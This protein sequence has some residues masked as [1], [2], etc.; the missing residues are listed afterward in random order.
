MN[1]KR[2]IIVL[3]FSIIIFGSS[4]ISGVSFE[5]NLNKKSENS[6]PPEKTVLITGFESWALYTPNP[7]QLIAENLSNIEINGAKVVS[8]IVPVLWGEAVDF[9]TQAIIDFEPDIVISIGTGMID[10]IHVEKIG[11]NL[12][13]CREPDNE[14]KIFLFRR[15]DPHGP[16]LRF[17]NLPISNIVRKINRADIPAERTY[18]AGS[19]IC[20]EVFYGVLN[21]I[22]RKDLSIDAGFIHV[23]LLSNQDPDNGMEL[24]DMIDAIEIAISACL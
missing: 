20:N 24:E 19:F 14:G 9:I 8:I 16:F 11:K 12:K 7:S 21:F 13:S 23:P 4:V 17:S 1:L 5:Y 22:D 18:N 10:S 6:Y 2:I 15:I 3:C